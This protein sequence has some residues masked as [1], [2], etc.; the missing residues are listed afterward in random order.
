MTGLEGLA[1][2]VL[3]GGV[4]SR[5]GSNKLLY[6]IG[7]ETILDRVWRVVA[8]T[9]DSIYL[10][11]RS[12][13]Q[14]EM[15]TGTCDV[16]PSRV[17]IDDRSLGC[18][19][20]VAGIL[21]AA[22]KIRPRYLLTIPG[23]MPFI[24]RHPLRRFIEVT[25]SEGAKA[26]SIM[27][28]RGVPAILLQLHE[29]RWILGRGLKISRIRMRDVRASDLLRFAPSLVLVGAGSI[30][31]NPMVFR[32]VNRPD[33]LKQVIKSAELPKGLWRLAY[34]WRGWEGVELFHRGMYG[35]AAH[36]FLKEGGYYRGKDVNLLA[37]HSYVDAWISWKA[38]ARVR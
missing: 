2:V 26:G 7:G 37:V 22:L 5:F 15:L 24:E 17:V 6:R 16:N 33:D 14:A 1:A 29:T 23:D 36:V 28:E 9:A 25:I 20:P 12:K 19:G 13:K 8:N 38:S 18:Q 34:G 35:P 30:G 10:A 3:A 31:E 32:N 21:S 27:V 11:V 4:S